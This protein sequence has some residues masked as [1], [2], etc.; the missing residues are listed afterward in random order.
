MPVGQRKVDITRQWK[1]L[2]VERSFIAPDDGL[3]ILSHPHPPHTSDS[4]SLGG[5]RLL[6]SQSVLNDHTTTRRVWWNGWVENKGEIESEMSG[7]WSVA[8]IRI[9]KSEAPMR[10][11]IVKG[12]YAVTAINKTNKVL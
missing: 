3:E 10:Y 2:G 7:A 1:R 9:Y 11:P 12:L 5:D 6:F 4:I 8:S